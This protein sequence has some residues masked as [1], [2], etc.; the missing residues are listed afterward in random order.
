MIL[1]DTPEAMERAGWLPV[2]R[3]DGTRTYTA[4]R[5]PHCKGSGESP[6]FDLSGSKVACECCRG[7][8]WAS[9]HRH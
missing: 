2:M 7:L 1:F 8:G 4:Y 6:Y 9:P 3:F 5:C